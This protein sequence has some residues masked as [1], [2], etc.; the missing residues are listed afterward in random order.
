MDTKGSIKKQKLSRVAAVESGDDEVEEK[1][2]ALVFGKQLFQS[3]SSRPT[4][5]DSSSSEEVSVITDWHVICSSIP[6]PSPLSDWYVIC[7]SI[8]KPS[9][10][11]DWHVICSSIPKPSPLSDWH[12][13]CSSI[14]KPGPLSDWHVICS[15]IPK[16]SP[17]S[18]HN[19]GDHYS[20]L[21]IHS[22]M[23]ASPR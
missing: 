7:S 8:P 11:S 14:P 3:S 6:K 10:L 12:V 19:L 23:M 16:P 15:S 1:L 13:I 5:G 20:F 17:L 4:E 2:E 21:L 18:G 22:V 9:P